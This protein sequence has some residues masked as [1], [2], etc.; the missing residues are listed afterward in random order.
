VIISYDDS[1]GWYDHVDGGIANP[2]TSVADGRT[3]VGACGTGTPLADEQGRCGYGPR[4]PLLVISPWARSNAV[5]HTRTDQS[6]ILRFVED[7]WR[8]VRIPGSFDSIAGSLRG[9]FDFGRGRGEPPNERPLI[10]DP[11]TGQP[12]RS[13]H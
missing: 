9:L 3:G 7:N 5:D 13:N 2:S 4:L 1:D 10:L 11:N 12:V 6:S 8:L